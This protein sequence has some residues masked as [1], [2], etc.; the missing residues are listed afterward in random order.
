MGETAAARDEADPGRQRARE[1]LARHLVWDNHGCMPVARPHDLSFLPQLS[2]YRAAGVDAV[3]L[4]VGF[5]ELDIEAHVRTLASLRH[6]LKAHADEFVLFEHPDDVDVARAT[7]RLAVGFD[8]EGAGAIDDQPSLLSLYHDLGVRWMLLAYNRNNRVGGG[9]QDDDPGLSAFGREVLQEMERIG[10]QVCLSHT[11]HR[12]AHDVLSIATRPVIFSH[13]N[14]ASVH[15]HP[16]NIPDDLVR[17]CAAGG[18]VVCLNG[19][20]IFLGRNDVSSETFARHVDHLVGLVGPRHVGLGLDYVFDRSEMDEYLVKHRHTFPPGL[21]Y[22]LGVQ[23]VPP[24]QLTDIVAC[25]LARGYGEKDLAAILGGNL[26]RVA[27]EVWP[28][29]TPGA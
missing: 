10:L 18:G 16:R 19:I 2:R 7:G 20:G 1:I 24:E 26:M 21:G 11:G 9:C 17:A 6:W 22:E 15:P 23:M 14:P 13:S 28:R 12:T 8:I 3:M 27:R 29:R 5:G 4:N 25:L